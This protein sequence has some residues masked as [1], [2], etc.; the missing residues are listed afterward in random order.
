MKFVD[1][2]G[3]GDFLIMPGVSN[4]SDM[5]CLK[6]LNECKKCSKV[7]RRVSFKSQS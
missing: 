5:R 7:W 2:L 1:L 6:E 4:Y 3:K